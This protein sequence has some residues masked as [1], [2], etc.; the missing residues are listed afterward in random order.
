MAPDPGSWLRDRVLWLVVAVTTAMRV[1][2][3]W[4]FF[5]FL[6]G[7]DVE[8]LEE[9]FRAARG[10]HYSPWNVRNLFLPDVLVAPFVRLGSALGL[11]E[12]FPL[13]LCATVPFVLLASLNIVLVYRLAQLWLSDRTAAR[14]AAGIYAFH[15]LPLA[16]GSTVYPRTVSTTFVLAA[17]IVLS[18]AG[19]DVARGATGGVLLAL[20]FMVRYSEGMYLLPSLLLVL[21]YGE[22]KSVSFRRALGVLAGFGLGVVLVSG[23]VNVLTW[24]SPLAS[25]GALGRLMLLGEGASG[26]STHP[27]LFYF[28]RVVFWLPPTLLPALFLAWRV[29]PVR[30]AWMFVA[31]P[32]VLLSF[33]AHKEL[34]YLQGAIPF[35]AILGAG[36]FAV[37]HRRWRPW[38]STTLVV[39]TLASEVLGVRVLAGKSMAAVTAARSMASD[40][41]V[42]VVALSQAWAY[43]DRL[44]FGNRVEVRGLP[45]PPREADLE[46][47]IPGADRF[48][49]Y[50]DDLARDPALAAVLARH[51]FTSERVVEWGDSKAVVVFAKPGSVNSRTPYAGF[52]SSGPRD[53][54]CAG[55]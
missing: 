1:F 6:G 12:T 45:V 27:P 53:R 28:A 47:A 19:K 7:D 55:Y 2:F 17:A 29:R 14:L 51:G 30:P 48:G 36:G 15:W 37:M 3:A 44:Y 54:S 41:G 46:K 52:W 50:R 24:G 11:A 40:I 49:L 42:R 39:L 10:L 4:R 8:I 31:V 33:I 22:G 18:G 20:A 38:L 9:A 16:Y 26:L 23:F 43:G 35:L 21:V 34:R 25:L 13:V 32:L 5:G